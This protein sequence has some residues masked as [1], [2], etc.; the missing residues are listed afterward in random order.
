MR[1]DE[2]QD[3]CIKIERIIEFDSLPSILK[4]QQRRIAYRK[5]YL[6]ITDE[7][8]VIYPTN[9]RSK[10]NIWLT[11]TNKPNKYQYTIDEIVY[12]VNAKWTTK[13]INLWHFHSVEYITIR[14]PPHN[15]PIFKFFLNVYINKFSLFCITYHAISGI[16]LQIGNM[17]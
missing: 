7:T 9:I 15:Q 6:W 13:L 1:I 12:F 2:S 10:V 17:K 4:T 16:Y 8:I 14:D 5:R 3:R 11:D